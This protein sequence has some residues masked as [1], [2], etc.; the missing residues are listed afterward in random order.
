MNQEAKLRRPKKMYIKGTIKSPLDMMQLKSTFQ[1]KTK[2]ILL[3]KHLNLFTN[4]PNMKTTNDL[5]LR[6]GLHK[7]VRGETP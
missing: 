1:I 5:P 4:K 7:V 6:L 3:V 2:S